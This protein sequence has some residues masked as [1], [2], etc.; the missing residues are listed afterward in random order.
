MLRE[1]EIKA[2]TGLPPT[3]ASFLTSLKL[4]KAA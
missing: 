3:L 4:S 2:S 1:H